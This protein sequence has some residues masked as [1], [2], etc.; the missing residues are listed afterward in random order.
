MG[1]SLFAILGGAA[2]S[3]STATALLFVVS[4]IV[5]NPTD[6]NTLPFLLSGW[7]LVAFVANLIA[8]STLGV[9]WRWL[10]DAKHWRAAWQ[11]WLPASVCGFAI[12]FLFVNGGAL[13]SGETQIVWRWFQGMLPFYAY[14][15]TLG[16]LTALFAWLIRRP[17]RDAPNPPTATP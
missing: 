8:A 9:A 12:A 3:A 10:A 13:L 16:G 17:D 7:I 6:S 14:G 2:G 4:A 15:A 1:R 5:G 11:Y